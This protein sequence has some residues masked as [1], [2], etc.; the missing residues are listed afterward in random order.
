LIYAHVILD[1]GC[2]FHAASRRHIDNRPS[3]MYV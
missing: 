1:D 3:R 2:V